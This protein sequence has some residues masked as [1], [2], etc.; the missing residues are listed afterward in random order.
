MSGI[1]ARFKRDGDVEVEVDLDQVDPN[2]GRGNNSLA[3]F[4]RW[5]LDVLKDAARTYWWLLNVTVSW[6]FPILLKGTGWLC[7]VLFKCA[8]WSYRKYEAASKRTHI[9]V[10]L[11]AVTLCLV[12]GASL[13]VRETFAAPPASEPPSPV[14]SAP[15]FDPRPTPDSAPTYEL[16]STPVPT[17]VPTPTPMP[18]PTLAPTP[19]TVP[20]EQRLMAAFAGVPPSHNGGNAIQFQLLFAEPVNTS[21]KVLRDVAIQAVNGAVVQ[22]KRVDGRSDLWA[23]TVE[24]DGEEDV[25]IVL[26]APADCEGAAA[27]CTGSG[28]VLVNSPVAR[29]PYRDQVP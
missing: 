7:S 8:A 14:F 3:E 5:C 9:A 26:S 20:G 18:T 25:V 21:Y 4:V 29:V 24:P 17:A 19:E 6:L 16:T 1:R 12:L 15:A 27:V 13:A 10:S 22:S 11:F 23:A 2:G 28:K